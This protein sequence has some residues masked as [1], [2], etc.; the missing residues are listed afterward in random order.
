MKKAGVTQLILQERSLGGWHFQF[1][2]IHGKGGV[3]TPETSLFPWGGY[4]AIHVGRVGHFLPLHFLLQPETSKPLGRH[5]QRCVAHLSAN[6]LLVLHFCVVACWVC[7]L[8]GWIQCKGSSLTWLSSWNTSKSKHHS[9][10]I[11]TICTPQIA[12]VCSNSW[13]SPEPHSP[14][15]AVCVA[16]PM[17]PGTAQ[18][19]MN[20][21][22]KSRSFRAESDVYHNPVN[23]LHLAHQTFF[24][25]NLWL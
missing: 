10:C 7:F 1:R 6:S 19:Q 18:K 4:L 16:N 23:F 9:F 13:G 20:S 24:L 15:R 17:V 8:E 12:V 3:P 5:L 21:G 22:T 11:P 14:L 2:L 25:K